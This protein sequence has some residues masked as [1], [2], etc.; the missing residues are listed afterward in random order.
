MV[1][2]LIAQSGKKTGGRGSLGPVSGE[3]ADNVRAFIRLV[4]EWSA[5][6]DR[7]AEKLLAKCG[8]G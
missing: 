6:D 3:A 8:A 4:L 7:R 2:N 1:R 5:E